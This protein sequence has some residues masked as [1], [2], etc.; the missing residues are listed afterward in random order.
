MGE[1]N[2]FSL[3]VHHGGGVP[4]SW[5]GGGTLIL[6][7]GIPQSWPGGGTPVLAGGE[8]PSPGWGGGGTPVLA[9]GGGGYPSPGRGVSEIFFSNFLFPKFFPGIGLLRGGR[10]ASCVHA[11]G[12]SCIT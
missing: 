1:G 6:A 2:S 5:P 4:Q 9:G 8:Y 3:S 10:Y 11:G 7:G 12:L